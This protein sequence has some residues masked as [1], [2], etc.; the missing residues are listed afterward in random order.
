MAKS[1][2]RPPLTEQNLEDLYTGSFP[3]AR[4]I[5]PALRTLIKDA[6]PD[7]TEYYMRGW[8]AIGYRDAKVGYFVGIFPLPEMVSLLF[9]HG[10]DLPD[11]HG[12]LTGT[13]TQTRHVPLRST[14]D[15]PE[16][17]I[18]DLLHEALGWIRQ[19]PR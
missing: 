10:I 14:A 7:A 19:K 16:A 2:N 18:R 11:P 15:I 12:V 8:G 6:V 1:K 3:E 13:G 9:E 17:V 4:E 5:V